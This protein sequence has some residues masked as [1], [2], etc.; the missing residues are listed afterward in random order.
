ML[1]DVRDMQ[2][3]TQLILLFYGVQRVE[4]QWNLLIGIVMIIVSIGTQ[5]VFEKFWLKADHFNW[6]SA[7][8]TSL[9][10]NLIL[11]TQNLIGAIAISFFAI[12]SKFILKWNSK[13]IF[14][15]SNIAIV[16]ALL[17]GQDFWVS[18]GQWGSMS[19][20]LFLILGLG[21]LIITK[22]KRWDISLSFILFYAAMV[23]ARAFWLGDPLAVPIHHLKSGTL[24]VFTFFMITDPRT[25][26]S[27][28]KGRLILAFCVAFISFIIHFQFYRYNGPLWGLAIGS[29]LV[30]FLDYLFPDI[31]FQ[32]F[33]G[34]K[35]E[36]SKLQM[37][38]H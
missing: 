20:F 16:A 13:H 35:N 3:V 30:P 21:F 2:V 19:L 33:Q 25:T 28:Y 10:L 12:A 9:S 1:K 36:I 38:H 15:P 5:Y 4:F 24:W 8:A 26:P 27:S 7:L 18:P 6:K 32:W 11:R 29:C 14:N 17:L 23:F 22:S 37:A 34:E 31:K